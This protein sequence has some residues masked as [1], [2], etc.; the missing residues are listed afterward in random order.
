MFVVVNRCIWL[1]FLWAS[2]LMVWGLYRLRFVVTALVV[3]SPGL[4]LVKIVVV[5][6]F[7][8]RQAPDLI[9]LVPAISAML[10]LVLV[11]VSVVERFVMFVLIMM[12]LVPSTASSF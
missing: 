11:I 7:R 10:R 6:F 12:T 9:R 3:R 5:T 4:L 1:A 2:T 8:V